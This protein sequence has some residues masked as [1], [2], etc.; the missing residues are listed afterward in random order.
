MALETPTPNRAAAARQD[1]PPST[2]A[3]TG[4]R[5]STDKARPISASL[6]RQQIS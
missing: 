1:M 6:L 2:A 5:K 4:S 3:I